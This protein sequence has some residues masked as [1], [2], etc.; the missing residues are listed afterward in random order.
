M[1]ED[2]LVSPAEWV[3][4]TQKICQSRFTFIIWVTLSSWH[5]ISPWI[6]TFHPL[7]NSH[8]L[9]YC[10]GRKCSWGLRLLRKVQLL[11][12]IRAWKSLGLNVRLLYSLRDGKVQADLWWWSQS[13]KTKIFSLKLQPKTGQGEEEGRT[14]GPCP[15]TL[16]PLV[17]QFCFIDSLFC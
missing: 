15:L 10:Q 11:Y 17:L 12:L 5:V 14:K 4:F 9:W 8:I 13:L 3:I 16:V 1:L 6:K 2:T 7:K